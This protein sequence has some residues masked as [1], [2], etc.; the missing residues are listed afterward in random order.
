[1]GYSWHYT[2]IFPQIWKTTKNHL[3]IA[4]IEVPSKLHT[5]GRAA[6]VAIPRMRLS[7]PRTFI[8][9]VNINR[10]KLKT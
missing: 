7:F 5:H 1:M 8:A 3:I 2:G 4:G 9:S 10:I 6:A